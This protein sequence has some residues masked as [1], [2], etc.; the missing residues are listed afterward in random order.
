M[1]R[2]HGAVQD[3]RANGVTRNEGV[4]VHGKKHLRCTL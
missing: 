3:G 4:M 2:G 1:W